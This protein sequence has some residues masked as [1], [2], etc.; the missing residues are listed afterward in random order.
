MEEKTPDE[1]KEVGVE[2]KTS[3]YFIP[4]QTYRLMFGSGAPEL[5]RVKGIGGRVLDYRPGG[6]GI[7]SDTPPR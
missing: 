5:V 6:P 7:W 1:N 2:E 4:W 3:T